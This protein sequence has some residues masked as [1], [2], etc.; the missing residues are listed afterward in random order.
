[1]RR[2]PSSLISFSKSPALPSLSLTCF[3][4]I[5]RFSFVSSFFLWVWASEAELCPSVDRQGPDYIY[6][7]IH[8]KKNW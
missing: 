5:Y 7:F 6:I 8:Q 3:L 4:F 2:L 1:M